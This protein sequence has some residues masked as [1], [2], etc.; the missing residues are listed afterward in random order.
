MPRESAFTAYVRGLRGIVAAAGAP[1]GAV[2]AVVAARV[3]KMLR[4]I[5]QAEAA[6]RAADFVED[7]GEENDP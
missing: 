1:P 4:E 2:D 6:E 7:D 5:S 3:Q